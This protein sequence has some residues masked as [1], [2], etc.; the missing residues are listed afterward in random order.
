MK[1]YTAGSLV[2]A[3]ILG[4]LLGGVTGFAL[5]LLLAPEEGKKIRRRL[6]YQLESL[7]DQVNTFVENVVHPEGPGDARQKGDAIVA[8]ARNRAQQIQD[9]IDALMGEARRQ[10]SSGNP[11][12]N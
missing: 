1:E 4:A 12:A 2:R 6:A 10:G 8:D 9:D 11:T 7:A 5:G 3:G